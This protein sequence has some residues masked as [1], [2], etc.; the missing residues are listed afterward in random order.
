MAVISPSES[1]WHVLR[2]ES[3][4]AVLRRLRSGAT[5]QAVAVQRACFGPWPGDGLGSVGFSALMLGR[6][7]RLFQS[8]VAESP[9]P[10]SLL[11][12]CTEVL[13][14]LFERRVFRGLSV[15]CSAEGR[16]WHPQRGGKLGQREVCGPTLAAGLL[17][18]VD[19][20]SR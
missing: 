19:G 11:L 20:H 1:R 7:A 15:D 17:D 3:R 8:S 6:R 12:L 10:A 16:G 4:C 2:G 9:T 14:L 13:G 5:A 18:V